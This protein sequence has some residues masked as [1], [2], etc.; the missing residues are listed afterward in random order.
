MIAFTKELKAIGKRGGKF[1]Y[2]ERSSGHGTGFFRGLAVMK[3]WATE[4][5]EEAPILQEVKDGEDVL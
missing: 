1:G 5:Y 2:V 3:N 4:I